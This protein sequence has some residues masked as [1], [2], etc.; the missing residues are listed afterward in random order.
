MMSKKDTIAYQACRIDRDRSVI[1]IES[2][3]LHSSVYYRMAINVRHER[4]NVLFNTDFS[5]PLLF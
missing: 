3:L 1:D 2:R 5:K 4:D